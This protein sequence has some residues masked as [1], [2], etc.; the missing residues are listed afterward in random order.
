MIWKTIS[1]RVYLFDCLYIYIYSLFVSI[2]GLIVNLLGGCSWFWS[3]EEE[4]SSSSAVLYITRL[5]RYGLFKF[6]FLNNLFSSGIWFRSFLFLHFGFLLVFPIWVDCKVS[7]SL[8]PWFSFWFHWVRSD[9]FCLTNR[10][11]NL[12]KGRSHQTFDFNILLIFF[13]FVNNEFYQLF[14][15]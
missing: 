5:Q 6:F 9:Q 11:G 10:N 14:S 7:V 4:L 15:C 3:E 8:F 2:L 13:F 1:E 12:V